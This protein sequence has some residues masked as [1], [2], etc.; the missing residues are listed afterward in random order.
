MPEVPAGEVDALGRILLRLARLFL[1]A[2]ADSEYVNRRIEKLARRWD[3]TSELFIGSERLL[4]MLSTEGAYRTRIGHA[5]GAMGVDAGRLFALD[6]L[7]NDIEAG[8]TDAASAQ[9]RLDEIEGGVGGYSP[10]VVAL[11]VAVTSAS[12]ALLFGAGPIAAAAAF[13]AGA[14]SL[15][16]RRQLARLGLPA[17]ATAAITA[18][19]SGA[20]GA[21]PLHVLQVD[22]TLV[23]VAA[24]MILVPG[25]PLINGV[26]DL[27][28][29]HAAIGLD[30]LAS[31]GLVV[32][33]IVC[34]LAMASAL[35]AVS[36]PFSSGNASPALPWDFVLSGLAALGFAILFN[37]P[38]R[39]ILPIVLCG[40]LSHGSR[41]L[42]THEGVD[43]V[44]AT[45]L[46]T[47]LAGTVAVLL[48]RYL[49]AP[50]AAFAFPGVVAMVPGAYAFHGMMG[51]V[52]IMHRGGDSAPVLL[53]ET[54]SALITAGALT[55]AIGVGLLLAVVVGEGMVT[56]WGAA[57]A[58]RASGPRRHAL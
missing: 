26:R 39:S 28:Q 14:V 37:A 12:L 42:M 27:V 23:L 43:I 29:G 31:G 35:C 52:E 9:A 16:L 32:L 49:E 36:L 38:A 40:A 54:F 1:G 50:W 5:V 56:V 51:A 13:V 3:A 45:L 17:A 55:A 44:A 24:G 30:R 58:R 57:M 19:V 20:V 7:A 46:A 48:A 10:W 41:S 34:G 33:A 8:R 15:L 53:G 18:T 11:A 6:G 2:G 47:C 22:A 21:F 25:V 4:L